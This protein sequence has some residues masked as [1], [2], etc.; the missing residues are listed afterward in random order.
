MAEPLVSVVM[1]AFNAENY[2]IEAVDSVLTQ[3]YT[4]WELFVVN[5]GSTDSTAEILNS[6]TDPRIKVVHQVNQGVSIARNQGL[7]RMKGHFFTFLDAD[8]LWPLNSL[9]SR[10]RFMQKNP[11]V[12]WLSGAVRMFCNQPGDYYQTWTPCL[13]DWMLESSP[14]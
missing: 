9:S 2:I 6:Y 5:D 12:D 3:D 4:N 7:A 10:I 14:T 11:R 1:P 8:D 13:C